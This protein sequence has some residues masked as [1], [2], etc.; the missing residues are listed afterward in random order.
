MK[1]FETHHAYLVCMV[2]VAVCISCLTG[3]GGWGGG[4][5][6]KAAAA[7]VITAYSFV[8]YPGA[9]GTVNEPAKTIAVTLPFGTDVTALTSRFITTGTVV[10]IGS[11]IQTSGTTQNDFTTTKEY[12]VTAADGSV[13][14]QSELDFQVA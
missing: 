12:T 8:E 4:V 5:W 9:P 1:R 3:C 2:L 14:P 6:N 10:K 13:P 7:P 11:V